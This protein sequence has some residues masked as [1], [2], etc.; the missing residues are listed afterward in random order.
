MSKK[1]LPVHPGAFLAELLKELSISQA[2]LARAIGVSAMRVSHLVNGKRPVTAEIALRLARFFGQTP[3]YW[4]NLQNRYDLDCAQDA[5]GDRI[6]S[7]VR[8]LAA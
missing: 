3:Q 5:L 6:K 1:L 7:L 2:Q 8:P 4:L